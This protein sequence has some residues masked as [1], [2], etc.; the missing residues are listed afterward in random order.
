MPLPSKSVVKILDSDIRVD[1]ETG[2]ICITDIGN[3][4][5]GSGTDHVKNW[6]R[7]GRSIDFFIAW[8]VEHNP[9]FKGVEFDP[10]KFRAGENSFKLSASD[11]VVAGAT[12]IFS[13]RG[14]SGGTYCNIDWTI[15]FA[16]W[17][18]PFFYVKT[19]SALRKQSD[20]L[21]G[22]EHLHRRFA[23][24]IAAE[25]FNLVVHG[26]K[27]S[28]PEKADIMVR[29]HFGAT[30]ADI[31]NI[32]MWNMTAKEWRI[33]TAIVDPHV[34]MRDYAT[35]EELKVLAALQITMRN[36]QEDQYTA[37]EKLIRLCNQANELLVHYCNTAEKAI[38]YNEAKEKR[39]W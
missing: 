19:V 5:D 21:F 31:L 33:K 13:R 3:L 32:A 34:T 6:L 10:F 16:N 11:L 37:E 1:K 8:E 23:R 36:L 14:R 24:E 15:H 38:K 28:L 7:N 39:G 2:F 26:I 35:T 4:K 29:R 27:H 20:S 25:N 18:D 22:R 30:E 17:L 12:G 9:Q